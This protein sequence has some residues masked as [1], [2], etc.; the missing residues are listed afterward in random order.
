MLTRRH[1]ISAC[2]VVR[3]SFIPCSE[4]LYAVQSSLHRVYRVVVT[5]GKTVFG[6]LLFPSYPKVREHMLTRV[7]YPMILELFKKVS[8][9][10]TQVFGLCL[11]S[12]TPWETA[13]PFRFELIWLDWSIKTSTEI[14]GWKSKLWVMQCKIDTVSSIF[15]VARIN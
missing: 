15:V 6:F 8:F 9:E 5:N 1:V 13:D 2:A 4:R 12:F 11:D 14:F 3:R 7:A 10:S